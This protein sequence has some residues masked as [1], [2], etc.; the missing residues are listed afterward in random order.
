M[1]SPPPP[2]PQLPVFCLVLSPVTKWQAAVLA[3]VTGGFSRAS[4][5]SRTTS[6]PNLFWC[7]WSWQDRS[8]ILCVSV[9][10]SHC[11]RLRGPDPDGTPDRQCSSY[12]YYKAH[13]QSQQCRMASE[14]EQKIPVVQPSSGT[15][16]A[17]LMPAHRGF[18]AHPL[19]DCRAAP[20][21]IC[22]GPFSDTPIF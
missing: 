3:C 4:L 7:V 9:K 11:K 17:G 22:I 18:A 14:A 5:V 19:C 15:A 6:E 12:F 8:Q 1:F 10:R 13:T 21:V 20:A 2:P 16:W